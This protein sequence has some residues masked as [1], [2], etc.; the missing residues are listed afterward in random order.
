MKLWLVRQKMKTHM[1]LV[2]MSFRETLIW[3][4]Y[5]GWTE[6]EVSWKLLCFHLM[7]VFTKQQN[8]YHTK[9]GFVHTK[10]SYETEVT[11]LN[12]QDYSWILRVSSVRLCCVQGCNSA[13]NI[14]ST[15]Q[16]G[17]IESNMIKNVLK[18]SE[19]VLG[20]MTLKDLH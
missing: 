11:P 14:C 3:I 10:I 15:L 9:H 16:V 18:V 13:Y 7:A 8:T 4:K 12:F 19:L 17:A 6:A 20:P 1:P 5:T 2:T